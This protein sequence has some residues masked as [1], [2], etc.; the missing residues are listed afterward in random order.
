VPLEDP[1]RLAPRCSMASGGAREP[2]EADIVRIPPTHVAELRE[3]SAVDAYEFG[4]GTL[5]GSVQTI[6]RLCAV[7]ECCALLCMVVQPTCWRP[8]G[9]PQIRGG[10]WVGEAGERTTSAKSHDSLLCS[11]RSASRWLSNTSRADTATKIA[12]A[13]A[14]KLDRSFM[15]GPLSIYVWDAGPG[16]A[17]PGPV[18]AAETRPMPCDR[19]AWGAAAATGVIPSGPVAVGGPHPAL[20]DVDASPT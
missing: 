16:W 18:P 1:L 17:R 12:A 20:T 9:V 6:H 11:P 4:A 19:R 15:V 13:S 3:G 2:P 8:V 7:S 5:R 14:R 10:R